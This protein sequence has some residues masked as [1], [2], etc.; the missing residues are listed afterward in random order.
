MLTFSQNQ[1]ALFKRIWLT[2]QLC[3]SMT[4]VLT[5]LQEQFPDF[6][7]KSAPETHQRY[8][9][10][11]AE[12]LVSFGMGQL[13]WL[14]KLLS[15]EYQ[16]HCAIAKRPWLDSSLQ[17]EWLLPEDRLKLIDYLLQMQQIYKFSEPF[18]Y[19]TFTVYPLK[20]RLITLACYLPSY[21]DS[22][23]LAMQLPK[24]LRQ[25]LY[26]SLLQMV[27]GQQ[28]GW[29]ACYSDWTKATLALHHPKL[30]RCVQLQTNESGSDNQFILTAAPLDDANCLYI[31]VPFQLNE[32]RIET[33]FKYIKAWCVNMEPTNSETFR[34][35][36]IR[37]QNT[38][39]ENY[40]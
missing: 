13:D 40:G 16:Y 8:Y 12:K 4:E 38:G 22:T 10:T 2:D 17:L 19:E 11:Q 3:L 39:E 9:Y 21:E 24:V 30:Q 32:N 20:H 33:L 37:Q 6:W 27:L 31:T 18:P 23:D 1:M 14:E 15:L 36:M 5:R 34:A 29:Q 35:V 7:G 25:G 28:Q 26:Y